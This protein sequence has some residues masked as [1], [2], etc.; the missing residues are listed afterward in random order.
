MII[1]FIT[2]FFGKNPDNTTLVFTLGAFFIAYQQWRA[3]RFEASMDKYYD[4]LDVANRR[5]E[6]LEGINAYS[7]YV[8]M[9]LDNLEYVIEKYKLGYITSEQ[10]FRELKAFYRHCRNIKIEGKLFRN[11]ALELVHD[12]GYQ[13]TTCLV[14]KKVYDDFPIL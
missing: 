11:L 7:M 10:A 2:E 8:F 5:L 12:A 14:V 13:A 1:S 4:R 9:E 3:A 6:N